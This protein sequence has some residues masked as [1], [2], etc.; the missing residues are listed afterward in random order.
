MG[1]D[2][3]NFQVKKKLILF[4]CLLLVGILSILYFTC[5]NQ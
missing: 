2:Q 1:D 4:G 3:F 5:N